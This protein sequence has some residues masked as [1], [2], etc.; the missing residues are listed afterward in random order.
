[1]SFKFLRKAII[2]ISIIPQKK[3]NVNWIINWKRTKYHD[4]NP[5]KRMDRVKEIGTANFG[6]NIDIIKYTPI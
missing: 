4:I 3:I 6:K 2:P 5:S 1:M